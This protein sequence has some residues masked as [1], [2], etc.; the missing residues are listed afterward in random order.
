ML[1]AFFGLKGTELSAEEVDFFRAVRPAGY[2]LFARNCA[3]PA[4]ILALTDALRDLH[5][6]GHLPI[7]IDQEGGR[8]ARL[9]PPHWRAHPPAKG[10]GL[11]W[12]RDRDHARRATA[13]S[14]KLIAAE[15]RAL[16]IS[17]DCLPVLDI[18]TRDADP[19]IGDRA[20]GHD[21]EV[22]TDLGGVAMN[23][24]MD[25]GIVPVIKHI[26]GHGRAMVDSH[27]ALPL[28]STSREDLSVQDFAPFK[29][30]SH[31]PMAMTAHVVYEALDVQH[32]ATLS[33]SIIDT[34]IRGEIGFDGLL[35]SDDLSMKALEGDMTSRAKG[36]ISAGCDIVL[37]CNGDMAEMRA[38][39]SA[40]PPI[41]DKALSRLENAMARP[42]LNQIPD[43][44]VLDEWMHERDALLAEVL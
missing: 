41:A 16:G 24:L 34:I 36:A 35:M 27:L 31:A 8:V 28:V 10:F 43:D 17:V 40:L 2:I 4:Q 12:K 3:T 44:A 7:L 42:I 21:A 11:L 14:V 38:V 30:L 33:P 15:L 22:V 5:G 26:P 18:P 20:Y 25:M 19:I 37:H 13:L 1:P 6:D 23:A 29:A 39:A 32:C 9:R